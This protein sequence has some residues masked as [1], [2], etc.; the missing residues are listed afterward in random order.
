M[1][2]RMLA[3]DTACRAVPVGEVHIGHLSV[4]I[5][6]ADNIVLLASK[7]ERL[8][9]HQPQANTRL[10]HRDT[11]MRLFI[12]LERKGAARTSRLARLRG[13]RRCRRDISSWQLW[14]HGGT[15]PR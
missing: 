7:L 12:R 14:R 9:I 5:A 1:N 11:G 6:P 10:C 4:R 2:G 8:A 13:E 3:R 15:D